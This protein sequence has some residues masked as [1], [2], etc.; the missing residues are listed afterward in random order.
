MEAGKSTWDEQ[1]KQKLSKTITLQAR[2]VVVEG[3]PSG[4]T[5][6]E[7]VIYFQKKKNNGGDVED[8]KL[9]MQDGEATVLFESSDG[10]V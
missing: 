9:N 7:I 4:T 6:N 10:M 3:L 8:V 2:S 5:E 1:R